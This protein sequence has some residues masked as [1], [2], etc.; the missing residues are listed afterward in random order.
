MASPS[1]RAAAGSTL[2][3]VRLLNPATIG[4]L[5]G[6]LALA[7]LAWT[8]ADRAVRPVLTRVSTDLTERE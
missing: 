7:A 6:L 4:V 1:S 5:A 2:G 8:A 3:A